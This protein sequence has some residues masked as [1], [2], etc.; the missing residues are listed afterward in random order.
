[1]IIFSFI[2][3]YRQFPNTEILFFLSYINNFEFTVLVVCSALSLKGSQANILFKIWCRYH[4]LF[5]ICNFTAMF[6]KAYCSYLEVK[7]IFD[8]YL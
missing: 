1:M 3:Y 4:F 8:L 7:V 2:S 6:A 5:I